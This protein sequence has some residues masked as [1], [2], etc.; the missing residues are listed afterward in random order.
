MTQTNG[1]AKPA[2]TRPVREQLKRGG[3][4]APELVRG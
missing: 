3:A 1:A 4:D 2:D